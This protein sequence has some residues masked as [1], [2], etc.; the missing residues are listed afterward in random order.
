LGGR[1]AD[2]S[3]RQRDQITATLIARTAY[4]RRRRR[5]DAIGPGGVAAKQAGPRPADMENGIEP[6]GSVF[7]SLIAAMPPGVRERFERDPRVT[8]ERARRRLQKGY[9]A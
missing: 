3:R 2:T 9:R 7:E 5:L 6:A 4:R 1:P 8:A